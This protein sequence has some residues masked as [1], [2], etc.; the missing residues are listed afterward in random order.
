M[1]NYSRKQSGSA[2]VIIIVILVLA[3]LGTLGFIFWQN[4][5]ASK[6]VAVKQS[7]TTITPDATSEASTIQNV[8]TNDTFSFSYP[9]SGWSV[10]EVQYGEN[11]PLTPEL[12]TS[13]YQQAGMGVDKGAIIFVSKSDTTTTLDKEYANLQTSSADFGIEELTKTTVGGNAV[14]TYHSAYEGIRYHTLMVHEGELYDVVYMYEYNGNATTY[15]DTYS[16]VASSFKFK[17]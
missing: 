17:E 4:F 13:D 14:I 11:A 3:L 1:T 10:G 15:M 9:K 16:L 12:K 7:T 5:V 6:D 2:H 8:Y